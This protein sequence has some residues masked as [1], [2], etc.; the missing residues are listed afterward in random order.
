[1]SNWRYKRSD[2]GQSEMDQALRAA[3]ASVVPLG[4]VGK[5]CPDRL[6]G[7]RQKMFLIEAK[8]KSSQTHVSIAHR[9]NHMLTPAQI[10]FHAEWQGPP[11]IIAYTPEEALRAIGAIA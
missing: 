8:S 7:F 2:K 6:V 4:D 9:E 3:G 5:G 1:M 11:I 10:K